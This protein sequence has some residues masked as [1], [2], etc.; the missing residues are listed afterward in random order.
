MKFLKKIFNNNPPKDKNLNKKAKELILADR[1]EVNKKNYLSE[2]QG[3]GGT[4]E[5]SDE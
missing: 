5:R 1:T 2:R 4:Q 3:Q